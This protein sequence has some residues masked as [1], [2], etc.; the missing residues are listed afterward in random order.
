MNAV[1]SVGFRSPVSAPGIRTP[2]LSIPRQTSV[3]EKPYKPLSPWEA[4]SRSAIGSVD[5]AFMPQG[6]GSSFATNVVAAG[7]RRALPEPPEEWKRRVSLEPA[8]PLGRVAS[9]GAP[10]AAI[11]QTLPP[12]KRAFTGPPFRPAQPL[13]SGRRATIGYMPQSNTAKYSP[14]HSVFHWVENNHWMYRNIFNIIR[15][16]YQLK[17]FKS[18]LM[19]TENTLNNLNSAYYDHFNLEN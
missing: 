13:W 2:F 8:P 1:P 11:S 9:A 16:W 10:A 7:N 4:A 3:Q 14:M 6:R 18:E 19:H 17:Y 5:E 12:E 15:I